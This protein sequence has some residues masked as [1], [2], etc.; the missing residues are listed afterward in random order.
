LTDEG[1][2]IPPEVQTR[3]FEPF[4]TT[5]E[6]GKGTGLGLAAVHGIVKQHGGTIRVSSVVGRGTTFRVYLPLAVRA[7]RVEGRV[8]ARETMPRG[9]G[10]RILVVDDELEVADF[11]AQTLE[12]LG[13]RVEAVLSAEEA[14]QRF[15]RSPGAV[16][17]LITDQTMPGMTGLALARR[18]RQQRP[19]LPVVLCTGYA[20]AV[21]TEELAAAGVAVL[22]AKPVSPRQLAAEV[23]RVLDREN[24]A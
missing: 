9:R 20:S 4:F 1:C 7:E 6:V 18:C 21:T 11:L 15:S 22:L 24:G 10:E 16:D 17:L 5:K 8:G 2:G 23:R 12:T 3:I 14:W 13:Y 19:D